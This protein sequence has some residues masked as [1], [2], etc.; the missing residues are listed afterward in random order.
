LAQ[1]LAL[2]GRRPVEH[3]AVAARLRGSRLE[4][5]LSAQPVLGWVEGGQLNG[6]LCQGPSLAP[7]E[8]DGEALAAFS[9]RLGGVRQAASIVGPRDQAM[10]LWRELARRHP[11]AWGRPRAVR[12][13]QPVLAL[14][15]DPSG[16]V[17]PRVGPLGPVW[18]DSY[19]VA[20]VAMYTEEI[21]LSP[22][23][24]TGSYRRHVLSSLNR[25]LAFGLVEAGQ[26]VFK[27]DVSVHSG[28]VCQLG[29]VWLRP[30]RRGRGTAGP[31]LAAVVR[32]CRQRWPIVCLYV[33]DYNRRA[34][35]LYRRLGFEQVGEAATVLF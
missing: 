4:P 3:V 30:D 19:Y 11:W 14:D 7:V 5:A 32:L 1:A 24:A 31:A 26:V 15:H 2:V 13:C 35:A 17:D 16:P 21:G 22:V 12:A 29:G 18:L 28:S 20:A 6:L 25:G 34:L 9:Q 33:N 23:E 27:T 10:G 8:A